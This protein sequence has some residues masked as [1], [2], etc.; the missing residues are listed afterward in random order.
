MSSEERNQFSSFIISNNKKS[1]SFQEEFGISNLFF[2]D[3]AEYRWLTILLNRKVILF[4]LYND[5]VWNGLNS[6]T[7]SLFLIVT[8]KYR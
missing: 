5:F 2:G 4:S 3:S 1:F 6:L 8:K 7:A